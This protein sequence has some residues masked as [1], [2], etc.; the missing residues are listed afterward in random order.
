MRICLRVFFFIVS[1][2][3]GHSASLNIEGLPTQA[4]LNQTATVV[5]AR[6][7]EDPT[8]FALVVAPTLFTQ[9]DVIWAG[10]V[11]E[12]V[13]GTSTMSFTLSKDAGK[14]VTLA[15]YK[16]GPESFGDW[17]QEFMAGRSNSPFFVYPTPIVI[18][19][20]GEQTISP[21]QIATISEGLATDGSSA[22]TSS[23]PSK[24]QSL[25]GPITGTS[26]SNFNTS[27]IRIIVGSVVGF[28]VVLFMLF[29]LWCWRRKH[30]RR[31]IQPER[32]NH[33]VDEDI[34][35]VSSPCPLLGSHPDTTFG[36]PSADVPASLVSQ[37]IEDRGVEMRENQTA[38]HHT[39]DVHLKLDMISRDLADLRR[40]MH[41]SRGTEELLPEYSQ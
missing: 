14:T 35:T 25:P 39:A 33:S 1:F 15:A 34:G 30:K 11:E 22:N 16:Y 38:G 18:A 31:R 40:M 28:S 7:Q 10:I 12:P 2:L 24:T 29:G 26:S 17:K 37:E 6:K 20:I 19:A 23:Q 21:S 32:T 3:L 27:K 9:E 8:T 36:R 5:W 13:G 41:H 4:T